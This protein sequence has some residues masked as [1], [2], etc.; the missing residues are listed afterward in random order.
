MGFKQYND[1][2][3]YA[4]ETMFREAFPDFEFDFRRGQANSIRAY[5]KGKKSKDAV[6]TGLQFCDRVTNPKTGA[7][8]NGESKPLT[9]DLI[10]NFFGQTGGFNGNYRSVFHLLDTILDALKAN[11]KD[12]ERALAHVQSVSS[13][14]GEMLAPQNIDA[15]SES[16]PVFVPI[17]LHT[18]PTAVLGKV[19]P[20][21]AKFTRRHLVK[22]VQDQ[23]YWRFDDS[24]VLPIPIYEDRGRLAIG[25]DP[26]FWERFM[27][28]NCEALYGYLLEIKSIVDKY[29]TN[30]LDLVEESQAGSVGVS[31]MPLFEQA[32]SEKIPTCILLSVQLGLRYSKDLRTKQLL[33]RGVDI[34]LKGG[35]NGNPSKT[36]ADWQEILK[37]TLLQSVPLSKLNTIKVFSN[38]SATSAIHALPPLPARTAIPRTRPELIEYNC[39]TWL[40]FLR[41]TNSDGN[42]KFPSQCMGELR[43][44]K[45]LYSIVSA[46]DFSRQILCVFGEGADG[47]SV[48]FDAITKALNDFDAPNGSLALAGL[49]QKD[50]ESNFGLMRCIN[51]RLLVVDDLPSPFEFIE[52][53]KI[54]RISG[55]GAGDLQVDIKF[56]APYTWRPEGCKIIMA[57]NGNMTLR[58]EANVSRCLPL[59]FMRNYDRKNVRDSVQ[60]VEELA[61]E[62]FGKVEGEGLLT[63]AIDTLLFYSHLRNCNG[64]LFP[65]LQGVREREGRYCFDGCPCQTYTDDMLTRWYKGELDLAPENEAEFRALRSRAFEEETTIPHRALSFVRVSQDSATDE[66]EASGVQEVAAR[67]LFIAD[68]DGFVRSSEIAE[69]VLYILQK[70]EMRDTEVYTYLSMCGLKVDA[71]AR[72]ITNG[73]PYRQF[74]QR[75]SEIFGFGAAVAR[76]IDGKLVKGYAGVS[77]RGFADL[78]TL[79]REGVM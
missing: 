74:L 2:Q 18:S 17:A 68:A 62:V 63:W 7:R 19:S 42:T 55:A 8:I 54:K 26:R 20:A 43:F 35:M 57:T 6:T 37:T 9:I 22:D 13:E 38:T 4:I 49:S 24:T 44:A 34:R 50:F 41:G 61:A 60:L 76:R 25:N 1:S 21:D 72:S 59:T 5:L 47:K 64:E 30:C 70:S 78:K 69:R 65:G 27:D 66:S 45:M 73:A 23:L 51:R 16:K 31:E 53:E 36:R 48:C 52:N 3:L 58:M 67:L 32:L 11:A 71:N 46:T 39:G 79:I 29:Q 12:R 40:E 77:L 15:P 10:E 33:N 75:A 14:A 28:E 56:G